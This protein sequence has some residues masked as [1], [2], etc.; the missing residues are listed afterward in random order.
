MSDNV[1]LAIIAAISSLLLPLVGVLVHRLEKVKELVN[2]HSSA[3]TKL[4]ERQSEQIAQ[5]SNSLSKK[6]G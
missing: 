6:G 1:L 4:I 2:G 5:L 3:Q